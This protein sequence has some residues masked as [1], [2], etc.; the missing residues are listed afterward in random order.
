MFAR[1]EGLRRASLWAVDHHVSLHLLYLQ[2]TG[3]FVSFIGTGRDQ[4]EK[5][6]PFSKKK[7]KIAE[8]KWKNFNNSNFNMT[9]KSDNLVGEMSSYCPS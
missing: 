3:D 4:P 7:K 5:D 8:M 2:A 9:L 6:T 1:S